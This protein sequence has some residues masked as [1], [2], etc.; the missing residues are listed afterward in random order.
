MIRRP[1]RSTLFPYTT[2]FRSA[3]ILSGGHHASDR[4]YQ[5]THD[6]N[7]RAAYMHVLADA[8]TSVLAIIALAAG[9][10]FGTRWLDP[11]V[12][13]VGA[14]MILW[15]SKGLVR[16]SG[17]VLL[18]AESDPSLARDIR[19]MVERDMGAR[20]ADLHLW[21]VGPGHHSLIVSLVSPDQTDA[22]EIKRVLRSRH[23]G[24]SHVTVEVAV[25]AECLPETL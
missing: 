22:E 15:W 5:H 17:L 11:A 25:C 13:I 3:I 20:V 24:L 12:G 4:H 9:L 8:A 2:L 19:A 7:L 6:H 18:D 14:G 10:L 23:P 16:D 21:R 1:P